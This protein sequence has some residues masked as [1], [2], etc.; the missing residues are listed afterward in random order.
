MKLFNL[1]LIFLLVCSGVYAEVFDKPS[2][3]GTIKSSIPKL[4]DIKCKFKQEKH[5]Q[6]LTKTLISGGDFE[7]KKGSEGGIYFY[8]TYPIKSTVEYSSRNYKQINDI[9]NAISTGKYSKLER[10]FE[11]YY[12]GTI[13]GWTFGLKPKVNSGAYNY[14]DFIKVEGKSDLIQKID[15]T[16]KNSN[17]TE[18]WFTE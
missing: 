11:F 18:I 3:I 1:F 17:R 6:G 9:I 13:E 16:Q 5:I 10:N 8:T 14:L 12:E 7:F 2:D 15:I 4:K